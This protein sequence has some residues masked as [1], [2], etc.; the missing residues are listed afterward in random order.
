M[1]TPED[2]TLRTVSCQL[3]YEMKGSDLEVFYEDLARQITVAYG[4]L[5]CRICVSVIVVVS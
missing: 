5:C 1:L 2:L 3:C 4:F